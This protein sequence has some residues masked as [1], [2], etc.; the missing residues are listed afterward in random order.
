[1]GGAGDDSGVEA[2]EQTA[3]RADYDAADQ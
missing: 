2:E 3:Q 1:L